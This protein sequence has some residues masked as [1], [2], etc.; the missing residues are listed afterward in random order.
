MLLFI[1]HLDLERNKLKCHVKATA[2]YVS[3]DQGI[4]LRGKPT[5]GGIKVRFEN[6]PSTNFRQITVSIKLHHRLA[7]GPE[8]NP[9]EGSTTPYCS[10][11]GIKYGALQYI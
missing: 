11:K 1:K 5:R 2:K 10:G 6:K 8:Y 9:I 4:A 7:L 3:G